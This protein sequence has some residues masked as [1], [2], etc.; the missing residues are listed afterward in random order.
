MRAHAVE[1]TQVVGPAPAGYPPFLEKVKNLPGSL[2]DRM[3]AHQAVPIAVIPRAAL[4]QCQFGKNFVGV[5]QINTF[6]ANPHSSGSVL[7]L[8]CP[9][10]TTL[11]LLLIISLNLAEK[12]GENVRPTA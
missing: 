6:S 5:L 9:C 1:R 4:T 8:K 11:S 10:H 7:A 2:W 3:M 12:H